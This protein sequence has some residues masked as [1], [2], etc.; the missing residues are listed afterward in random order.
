MRGLTVPLL[1]FATLFGASSA[2]P[3]PAQNAGGSG[4]K[5]Q[6][7][8]YL[9]RHGVRSPTKKPGEYARFAAAPWPEWP[10]QPGYL[11]PHGYELMKFFGAYDRVK[12]ADEGLLAPAGCDDA[13]RVTI[14]AD[15]DQ[16]TRETGK[17]LA[18][19]L[20]PGC[21]VQTH[22]GISPSA[23]ALPVLR[24]RWS[25]SARIVTR[26]ASSQP[27]GASNPSSTSLMRSYAPKN[28]INS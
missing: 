3:T 19:G 20:M 10:V 14:L 25:L 6:F 17:A 2:L 24:V 21:A 26:V 5:L 18:E 11:T 23:S 9:S 8:I 1:G 22:P 12:L 28:F 16:R 4:E 7:V 13:T 15:S 27:A